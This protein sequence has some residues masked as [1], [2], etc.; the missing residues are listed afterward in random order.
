MIQHCI[1]TS[2]AYTLGARIA[3]DI[4]SEKINMNDVY[5]IIDCIRKDC[6]N[7]VAIAT[8][9][10]STKDSTWES[11]RQYDPFFSDVICFENLDDFINAINK[12]RV[13]SGMDVA[14]YILSKIKCTHLQLQELVY[15]AYAD[16]LC[17]YSERLFTDKIYAFRYGPIVSSIY[18]AYKYHG[19]ELLSACDVDDPM[20]KTNID[21]A[22]I[23]NRILFAKSGLR[24]IKSID[25]TIKK[26]GKYNTRQL[27][28][29]TH[30]DKAPWSHVDS[31]KQFAIIS[32]NIIKQYHR[33]ENI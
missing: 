21:Y 11:V 32:D 14:L 27:V 28:A 10:L 17:E 19:H 33:F 7:D 15:F 26:Y 3:F 29:I 24:K 25:E 4:S 16:Y 8:Q 20:V 18:S 30:R 5:D 9:C 12:S 6:G 31:T 13:L 23:K 1:I 2:S 22:S